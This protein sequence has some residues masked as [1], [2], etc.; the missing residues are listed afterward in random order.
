MAPANWFTKYFYYVEKFGKVNV[1]FHLDYG[2][3]LR[4]RLDQI[5]F[6]N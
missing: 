2:H 3:M 1:G 5:R 6:V 4:T